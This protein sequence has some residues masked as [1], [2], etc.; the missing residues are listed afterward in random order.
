MIG[1][2]DESGDAGFQFHR[3]SS[4]Y[5]VV[6]LVLFESEEEAGKVGARITALKAEIGK[7]AREFHFTNTDDRTR[8]AFFEA[9]RGY[10]FTVLAA[11][12]DKSK[13]SGGV[14]PEEFLLTAFGAVLEGAREAGLLRAA[15]LKYDEAGTRAFG[16]KFASSLLAKINGPDTGKYVTR[17]EPQGSRGNDLIQMADMVCGAIARPYNKPQRKELNHLATIKHRV[18]SVLEWP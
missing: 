12:C 18:N 8:Q 3:H 2:L 10:D 13:L 14:K 16:K 7:P 1:F 5:F 17:L 6:T 9:I 4:R 15:S 11:V